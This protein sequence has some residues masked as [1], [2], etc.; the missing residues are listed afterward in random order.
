MIDAGIT[1]PTTEA[2]NPGSA[3]LDE[4]SPL[5]LLTL[6]NNE[7]RGVADAVADALPAIAEVVTLAT[8]RLSQGGRLIYAGAGTSGRLGV[9]DAAECPP[10]FGTPPGQ[11]VGVLAGGHQAMFE[12]VEGAEDSAELGASDMSALAVGPH[13]VVVG[14]AAS[15][16]TPGAAHLVRPRVLEV[17]HQRTPGLG[18]LGDL[19][20]E[21]LVVGPV[22]SVVV[23][24]VFT[25]ILGS[26]M[27]YRKSAM[28]LAIIAS[29]PVSM[30]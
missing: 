11:V 23:A 27:A 4:L 15:G 3:H 19:L 7:D 2:R 29:A 5:A 18:P 9:L 26:M 6:M 30:M 1:S 16:R 22:D 12:A 25:R 14:I 17:G 21:P 24:H 13:D 28:R 20:F 8:E 10:T